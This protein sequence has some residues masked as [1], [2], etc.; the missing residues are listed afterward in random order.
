MVLRNN[1]YE[2]IPSEQRNAYKGTGETKMDRLAM[3]GDAYS[4]T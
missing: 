1:Y 4:V 2:L 3:L